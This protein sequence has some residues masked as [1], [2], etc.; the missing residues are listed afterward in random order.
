MDAEIRVEEPRELSLSELEELLMSGDEPPAR[1]S[2]ATRLGC[3]A[4]YV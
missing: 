2:F 4:A 1:Q 3:V